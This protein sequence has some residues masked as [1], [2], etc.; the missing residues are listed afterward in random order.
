MRRSSFASP[1]SISRSSAGS[2]SSPT[3]PSTHLGRAHVLVVERPAP[4]PALRID[5]LEPEPPVR[6]AED[7]VA[8]RTRPVAARVGDN[9]DLELEPLRGVDR[10]QPDRPCT[11]LLRN[12]FQ[13][14]HARGILLP[15]EADEPPDVGAAG[16]LERAR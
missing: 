2:S 1:C 8:P 13:L 5:D 10:Q 14:A 15:D 6:Q 12:C 16:L 11:F 3:R 7:L 9:N 4:L